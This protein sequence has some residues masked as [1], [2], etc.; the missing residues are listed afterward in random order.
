MQ[1]EGFTDISPTIRAGVYILVH[2]G[3]VVYVGKSKCM[4]NRIYQHRSLWGSKSRKRKVPNF[5]PVSGIP[6][7]EVHVKICK[8]EDLDYIE[9]SLIKKYKPKYNIKHK[10]VEKVRVPITLNI[11][12][13]ILSTMANKPVAEFRRRV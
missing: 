13:L 6:F 12:G 7:N 2:L 1:F 4:L 3:Q 8:L 10:P 9:Q 11:N 5:V